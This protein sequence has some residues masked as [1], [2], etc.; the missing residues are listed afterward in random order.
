MSSSLNINTYIDIFN[1]IK[2]KKIKI[3][4]EVGAKFGSLSIFLSDFFSSSKIYS[5]ECNPM[6]INICRKKINNKKNIFFYDFAFGNY[7]GL[8]P[9]YSSI[10]I[11]GTSSFYKRT[12]HILTQKNFSNIK[13]TKVITFINKK[14]INY[15]DLF[16]I[17]CENFELNILEGSGPFK[18][19]IKYIL[20][21]KSKQKKFLIDNFLKTNDYLIDNF[22]HIV[23]EINTNNKKYILYKNLKI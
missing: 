3:I 12:D 13:M 10:S 21:K 17:N 8:L 23:K 1:V 7:E 14:K 22:F 4:F 20:I 18:K 15:I 6:T 16:L 9:F 5:F 2:K 19:K 11:D